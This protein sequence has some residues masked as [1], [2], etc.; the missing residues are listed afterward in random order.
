MFNEFKKFIKRGNVLDL[1]IGVI[2]GAA[3]GK[4]VGSLVDDI[5]MPVIGLILKRVDFANLFVN[6]TPDKGNFLTIAAAKA[7]GAATLNYGMFVNSIVQ[8][9]IVAASLFLVIKAVNRLIE[10]PASAPP[11]SKDC[12]FCASKISIKAVRCPHCTSELN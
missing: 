12:P 4:I 7:A 6:L 2:I 11:D 3:F 9:M 8:F 1:A 10:K 5:F